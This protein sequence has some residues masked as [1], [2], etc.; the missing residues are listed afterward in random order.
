V[1][2]GFDRHWRF[3]SDVW[4]EPT[5]GIRFLCCERSQREKCC[6]SQIS[7]AANQ[8]KNRSFMYAAAKINGRIHTMRT[9]RDFAAVATKVCFTS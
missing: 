2:G 3:V 7:E 6:V 8:Q 9:K 5:L 4:F 1:T